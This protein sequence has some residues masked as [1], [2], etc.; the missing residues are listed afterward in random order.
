M[1]PL[2]TLF[3]SQTA[4]ISNGIFFQQLNVTFSVSEN[5]T[6]INKNPSRTILGNAEKKVFVYLP[7]VKQVNT[8]DRRIHFHSDLCL[9]ILQIH[10]AEK[11]CGLDK[12]IPSLWLLVSLSVVFCSHHWNT[13]LAC[14]TDS[15]RE[16]G[17]S[18]QDGEG[19]SQAGQI[20]TYHTFVCLS[21]NACPQ[22][23][24]I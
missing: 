7:R 19:N 15:D 16:L 17:M 21:P 22:T 6:N 3:S 8:K 11:F 13:H 1:S 10:R 9:H 23:F 2:T 24:T 4:I 18:S 14:V 20:Q 5:K 12:Q